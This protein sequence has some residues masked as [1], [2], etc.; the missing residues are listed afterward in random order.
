MSDELSAERFRDAVSRF[1]TGLVVVSCRLS[2]VDHAMTASSFVALSLEPLLVMVSI[3]RSTRFHEAAVG[4]GEWGVSILPESA[5]PTA[6]W[7]ATKG[8]P[9][10]GQFGKVPHHRGAVTGAAL[11]DGA[12][13]A[14]ECRT[15]AIYPAGD[16]TL[17][18]GEVL[19][20]EVAP[21]VARPLLYHRRAYRTLG[22]DPA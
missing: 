2:G 18:V 7:F 11:V 6:R 3:E 13:A 15:W 5:V 9:L 22:P 20:L 10:R 1:P 8:R 4:A 12:P 21:D 16:H 14:L 19:A 17:L